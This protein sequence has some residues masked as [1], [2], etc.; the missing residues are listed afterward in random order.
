[1]A[2]VMT[3]TGPIAP[4]QLGVTYAHEHLL[5]GPPDWSPDR[6]DRDLT[7]LSVEAA[8]KELEIFKLAGG[9][10]I[11]EM[12]PFDYNRQP[13]QLR[14]LS[15]TTGVHIIMTTGL[16]KDAYSHPLTS[17]ATIDELASSLKRSIGAA[18]HAGACEPPAQAFRSCCRTSHLVQVASQFRE[19]QPIDPIAKR[20]DRFHT[21]HQRAHLP[22]IEQRV[23]LVE[24]RCQKDHQSPPQPLR[25]FLLVICWR[26][27]R[28][29]NG[30]ILSRHGYPSS[31]H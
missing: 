13:E 11:V 27:R 5:G 21:L 6:Q 16:H 25:H 23:Y 14:N 8:L 9:Q 10:A 20:Q 7:M 17:E 30:E 3:V 4:S 22:L 29:I 28:R 12:S 24:Q 15:A 18:A 2:T 1:M 26:R 19:H 31:V